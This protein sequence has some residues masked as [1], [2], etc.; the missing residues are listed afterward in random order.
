[1]PRPTS[2]PGA[3]LLHYRLVERLGAGGMGVVWKAVD[4]TLEREVAIKILP[5]AFATNPGHISRFAGEVRLLA[6]RHSVPRT[7]MMKES[8]A[9][10][11]RYPGPVGGSR[12]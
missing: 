2:A 1:M 9:W 8:L 5:E 4:A 10:L 6:S 12:T 7:E 3:V 11:D